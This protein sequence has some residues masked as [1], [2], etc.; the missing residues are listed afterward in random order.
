MQVLKNGGGGLEP[1]AGSRQASR[2]LLRRR[3]AAFAPIRIK[4]V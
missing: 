3:G 4:L 2:R 1:V